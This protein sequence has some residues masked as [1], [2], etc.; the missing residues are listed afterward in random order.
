M[1]IYTVTHIITHEMNTFR[2]ATSICD[3]YKFNYK[4][5]LNTKSRKKI[6]FVKDD[7]LINKTILHDVNPR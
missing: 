4:S 3:F 6:P 2:F 5:F 7:Y 1:E